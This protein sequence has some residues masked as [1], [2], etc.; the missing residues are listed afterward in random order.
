[1]N[2]PTKPTLSR[3]HAT[4]LKDNGEDGRGFDDGDDFFWK[5]ERRKSFIESLDKLNL[6]FQ[7]DCEE[8]HNIFFLDFFT[9]FF[10][11]L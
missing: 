8:Q 5:N 2:I 4:R 3:Q 11:C 9:H 6:K 1:M 7:E 10:C